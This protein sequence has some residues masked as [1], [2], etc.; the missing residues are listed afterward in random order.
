MSKLFTPL[1]VGNSLLQHRVVMAPL[2]RLRA[3]DSHVPLDFAKEYYGQRASVPGTLIITEGTII[4]PRAGGWANVPGI[5]NDA[6]IAAWKSITSEVH[7]KGSFI[8]CQLAALGRAARVPVLDA[9]G[10]KFSAP[11]AVAIE[12]GGQLPQA[13]AEDE[14]LGFIS[15]FVQAANNAMEAGFDGIEIHGATGYLVDQ[16]IQEVSNLR[17]DKWGGSVEKNCRFGLEVVKAI[18]QAIG[19]EKVGLRLS[20]FS[21]VNGMKMKDPIPTFSYLVKELKAL[22]P[23]YLHL[24]ESRVAGSVDHDGKGEKLT[25]LVDI[26]DNAS[27]VFLAGGY[28]PEN[29][30]AAVDEEYKEKDVAVVFGRS[31]ISNPDLPFRLKNRVP[32]EKYNRGSFYKAKSQE[33]YTDYPLSKEYVAL[34]A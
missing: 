19:A 22:R 15:D 7:K 24:I 17:N 10:E 20:P 5:Y 31:F 1:Q 6:Q 28:T 11:S 2:T 16:F 9:E 21:I 26:F 12:E 25:F 33:G 34:Q 29:A 32:L 23:A 13:L 18:S 4:S 14:I 8:W 27:P 3:D 30:T